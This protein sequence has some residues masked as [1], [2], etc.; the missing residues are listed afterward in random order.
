M[1]ISEAMGILKK[2]AEGGHID[3]DLFEVFARQK[4]YL[5]YAQEF[6]DPAQIDE[7]PVSR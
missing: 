4:V 7:I 3:P 5:R 2:F 1:K 6:L